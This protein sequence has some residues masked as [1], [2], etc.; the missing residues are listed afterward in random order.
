MDKKSNTLKV[1]W[2]PIMDK[3]C[4]EK[5]GFRM[6]FF[7]AFLRIYVLACC[8]LQATVKGDR[9]K[10][11]KKYKTLNLKFPNYVKTKQLNQRTKICPN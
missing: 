1:E 8:G 10:V 6:K 4:W 9:L 2:I 11:R 7:L 3:I 5:I